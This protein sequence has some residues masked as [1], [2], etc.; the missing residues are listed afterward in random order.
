MFRVSRR[1][2][3]DRY[4]IFQLWGFALFLHYL[5]KSEDVGVFHN[6]PW[7]GISLILGHYYEQR[8]GERLKKCYG[9]RWVP[10]KVHHRIEITKPVWTVFFHFRRSNQWTVVDAKGNTLATEPWRAIGGQTK[11]YEGKSNE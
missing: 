5:H 6:H 11:Y 4:Y 2:T 3:A 8:L 10:A 9:I 1:D 7:T